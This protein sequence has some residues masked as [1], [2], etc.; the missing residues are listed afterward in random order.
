MKDLAEMGIQGIQKF[1]S[2]RTKQVQQEIFFLEFM[3]SI[4]EK[5]EN[6]IQEQDK[7]KIKEDE[8]IKKMAKFQLEKAESELEFLKNLQFEIEEFFNAERTEVN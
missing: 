8:L 1:A 6:E 2:E 7:R 5:L 3:C 4:K